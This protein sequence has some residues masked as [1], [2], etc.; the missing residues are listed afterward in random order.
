MNIGSNIGE[1]LRINAAKFPNKV[2]FIFEDIPYN[3]DQVI[4]RAEGLAVH[5]NK[6]G[7]G[8]GCKVCTLFYNS[9]EL[10]YAYFAT[11][12]LGAVLVSINF[13]FIDSEIAYIVTN[14]DA[15]A[16][17]HGSEFTESVERIKK[18][19]PGLMFT[20]E[21]NAASKD[22]SDY[23]RPPSS[24]ES[25]A[26]KKMAPQMTDESFI[27]YTSGTTGKPKGVVLTHSNNIWNQLKIIIDTPLTPEEVIIGSLPIFH[28]S[29]MSRL[30][31]SVMVGGTIVSWKQ[32]DAARTMAAV[33][34]YRG[35]FLLLVPAMAE[36]I[37]D[38]PDLDK[39][40]V[41]SLQ[42]CLL[43]AAP[44]SDEMKK[45]ALKLFF[46]ARIIDGYGLTENTSATTML[47]AK[48]VTD[49]TAGVGL[50]DIFTEIKILNDRLLPA[51]TGTVGEIAVRAPTVMKGYYKNPEATAEVIKNGWL[52]TG[53]LGRI[54]DG[55]YLYV[56]GRKK[57][58]IISGGENIYPAEMEA[59]LNRHPK[60]L[61][62]AVIGT[63]HPKWGETVTA[64]IVLKEGEQM[65]EEEVDAYCIETMAR[66]KRPRSIKFVDALIKNIAGKLKKHELKKIY[67][68]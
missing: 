40:K 59:L 45:R 20:L 22:G 21:L 16:L 66:Y 17:L 25:E 56:A 43:T 32:F 35:T 26:L 30:L 41:D 33:S 67:G 27:N 51:P 47:K 62:S 48:D 4:R 24:E 68:S 39:Y 31:A 2:G 38:L 36:M 54:D 61:E 28:S 65:T 14:S 11:L 57:E 37:F 50:P 58:M 34:K 1:G 46:N 6:K 64:L 3:Y 5:L 15:G 18:D 52:L 42:K 53:D 12:M 29:G 19:L 9:I 10:V 55:G 44:V 49:K 63:P 23:F 13:R 7:I 60:I 8:H